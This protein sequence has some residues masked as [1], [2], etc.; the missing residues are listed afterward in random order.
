LQILTQ[1]LVLTAEQQAG[2]KSLLEQQATQMRALRGK[3]QGDTE[4][5]PEARRTQM[6][7]IRDETNT[8]TSA[9]LNEDQKKTFAEW[10]AKRKAEME[11]R[12]AEG[13]GP[14]PPP[15]NE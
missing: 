4:A 2:V 14:P 1:R 10:V 6:D 12:R 15:P 11:K 8:K 5:N 9:L 7:Q 13:D 3:G